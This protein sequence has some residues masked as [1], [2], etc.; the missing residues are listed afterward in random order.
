MVNSRHYL[1]RPQPFHHTTE[2]LRLEPLSRDSHSTTPSTKP[3]R[4]GFVFNEST[5]KIQC[6]PEVY[7]FSGTESI[8]KQSRHHST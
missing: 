3:Y 1:Q 8:C 4:F 6:L 2:E 5:H 7:L